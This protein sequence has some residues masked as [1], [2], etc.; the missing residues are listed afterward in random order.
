MWPYPQFLEMTKLGRNALIYPRDEN[1]LG[2]LSFIYCCCDY[3]ISDIRICLGMTLFI[4]SCLLSQPYSWNVINGYDCSI[5]IVN[6]GEKLMY[7]TT[8]KKSMVYNKLTR[9]YNIFK[10]VIMDTIV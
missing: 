2:L 3:G 8:R 10:D 4:K 1:S 9:M 5:S 7:T 6:R